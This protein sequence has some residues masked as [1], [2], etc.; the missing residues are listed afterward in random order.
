VVTTAGDEVE[1]VGLLES[2]EG[3][4]HTSRV[5][6]VGTDFESTFVYVKSPPCRTE[7]DK[8]GAPFKLPA[9]LTILAWIVEWS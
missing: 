1:A 5:G 8:D 9:I 2:L 4:G 7:R 6:S 3:P